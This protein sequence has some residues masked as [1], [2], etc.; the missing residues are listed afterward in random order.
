MAETL[1][2]ER[3][4]RTSSAI[5][6]GRSEESRAKLEKAVWASEAER[7]STHGRHGASRVSL[8]A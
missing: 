4:A 5:S 8:H 6:R 7:A 1:A 3:R 2:G